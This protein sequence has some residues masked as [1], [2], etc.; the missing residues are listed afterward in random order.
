MRIAFLGTPLAAV[1]S[2][3]ALASAGH[4]IAAVVTQPDRPWGR[5]AA[6]Q[7]PA[8]KRAAAQLGAEVLQPT[9]LRDG[10][11]VGLL[12]AQRLD[13]L[14]VVAYGR[15]LPSDLLGVATNGAVNL[16]FSLLPLYRGAAPVQWALARGERVT[17]VTTML[18]N[19]GLDE[20]DIFMQRRVEIEPDE[21]APEL[22]GRLARIGAGLLVETLE[23]LA[24]GRLV[25]RPQ[26]PATA[27]L[28][29]RLCPADGW[30]DPA[31]TAAT[32]EGRV[33][34]FD[35]WP[36][37][38]LRRGERRIRL[39]DAAVRQA[40]SADLARQPGEITALV[41]G[42]LVMVCGEGTELLVRRIQPEGRR[43]LEARDAV[44][45]RILRPGDWLQAPAPIPT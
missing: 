39:I 12:A 13:A 16:H 30:V 1:P 27:T 45:G 25:A 22:E 34:G 15:I 17:G 14:V 35:P 24:A 37:A 29:P 23:G 10:R 21:H 43:V 26:D 2:L 32:I 44:N 41:E 5:S 8:V 7:S 20:G 4:T 19:E 31:W 33:R 42:G 11:L 18:I 40:A 38:W 9:R 3:E 36:G 28:A 6:P